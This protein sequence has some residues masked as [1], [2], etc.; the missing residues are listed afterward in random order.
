MNTEQFPAQVF[1]GKAH[2]L[3]L[4]T[5][6][7]AQSAAVEQGR[8]LC[9]DGVARIAAAPTDP[10]PAPTPLRPRSTDQASTH[11]GCSALRAEQFGAAEQFTR[12]R[13][14]EEK[15]S[16]LLTSSLPGTFHVTPANGTELD[17]VFSYCS[18]QWFDDE[19]PLVYELDT[20]PSAT[21]LEQVVG[22]VQQVR[23]ARRP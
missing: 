18:L 11:R 5:R 4:H 19:L 12:F 3:L 16:N 14:Y 10:D 6:G 7:Y 2:R 8:P 22:I 21:H 20:F 17:S 9:A 23:A 1:V 15:A 13:R